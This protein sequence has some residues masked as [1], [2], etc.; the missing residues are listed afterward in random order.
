VSYTSPFFCINAPALLSNA[1]FFSPFLLRGWLLSFTD[2]ETNE[3]LENNGG[4]WSDKASNVTA[5]KVQYY[6]GEKC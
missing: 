2:I 5:C 6:W 4:C 1:A 3:C